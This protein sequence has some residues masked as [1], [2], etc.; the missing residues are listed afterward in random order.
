MT[1]LQKINKFPTK[2]GIY[3]FKN[4]KNK[5]IYIGKS[6]NLKNR[7]KS[8]FQNKSLGNYTKKMISEIS[9]VDFLVCDNEFEALLL[10]ANS[11]NKYQ[12]QYNIQYR[13]DKS[14]LKIV[15]TK[16]DF[17]RILVSR[18]KEN[19]KA[20]FYGPF[21]SSSEVRQV[22]KFIR[23]T[24]PFR[25]CKN[26]P[27][28]PCLYFHLNLCPGCCLN[29]D[30]LEY[31][32]TIKKILKLLSGNTKGLLKQLEKEMNNASKNKDFEKAAENKRQ[33]DALNYVRENWQ[34]FNKDS[35]SLNLAVDEQQE[36]LKQ[37]KKTYSQIKKLKRIEAYDISNLAGLQATGSM[38]VF[39]NF[40]PA[41]SQYRRFKIRSK[42]TPDDISM[43]QEIVIRRL[44][45]AKWQYPDLMVIDGGK[46]QVG[47]V[48]STLR[49]NNL[50][51][52]IFVLGLAKKEE[53]IYIPNIK[54]KLIISWQEIKL[55]K[56]NVFLRLLQQLRN[57]SHRFARKYHLLLRKKKLR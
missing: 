46:G 23:Q 8:Y 27:K 36:I 35:L 42:N 45:H 43:M 48:F 5:I 34:S 37:A 32:K 12:P 18:K 52:K 21:I 26:L 19:L 7:V 15:I 4:S 51:N 20:Y 6:V 31:K 44:K 14:F 1:N 39:E 28:K 11:I 17:P 16:E 9:A 55:L 41:K 22:L 29:I 57:E 25:S 47:A 49:S 38:I 2:P 3:F 33:I 10:E 54:N 13:D 56:D 50:E 53:L 40:L 24:F 30:K